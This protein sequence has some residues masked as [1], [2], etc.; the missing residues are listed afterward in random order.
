MI[1]EHRTYTVAHGQMDEYLARYECHGLPILR[2]HL[3]RLQGCYLSEIGPL[4][5]VLHVWIYDS[6]SDR[7]RRRA[8]LEADPE[9]QA[10]KVTNRG[11]FT[12]QEV[13]ILRPAKFSPDMS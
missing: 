13:R 3:G 10:F 9:W 12:H 5:Q 11:T 6:L 1:I 8:Q 7:E 4:N 2:R